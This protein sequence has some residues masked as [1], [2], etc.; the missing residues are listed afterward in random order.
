[1][2]APMPGPTKATA[3]QRDILAMSSHEL[4]QIADDL[5]GNPAFSSE[6]AIRFLGLLRCRA[7]FLSD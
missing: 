1:M 7:R 5:D 4:R 3:L 2:M 6:N